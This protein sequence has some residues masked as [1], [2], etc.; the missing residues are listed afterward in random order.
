MNS[1]ALRGSL[2]KKTFEIKNL[3]LKGEAPV[4][5]RYNAYK[6]VNNDYSLN[7]F[8]LL[9]SSV[10]VTFVKRCIEDLDDK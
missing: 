1:Y 6:S 4:E 7:S 3:K 2:D 5:L 10:R 9:L 8:L